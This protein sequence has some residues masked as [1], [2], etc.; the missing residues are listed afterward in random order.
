[1]KC[2]TCVFWL[3]YGIDGTCRRWPPTVIYAMTKEKT[4]WPRTANYDYCGE[5][6]PTPAPAQ[7]RRKDE[8]CQ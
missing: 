2:E 3:G 4:V 5:H 6:K 8:R 1:M 7:A